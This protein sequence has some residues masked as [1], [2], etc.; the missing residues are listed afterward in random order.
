MASLTDAPTTVTTASPGHPPKEEVL[1]LPSR[2]QPG[3][4]GISSE[5]AVSPG[6]APIR[7]G[8]IACS[9]RL[10]K[11]GKRAL[12][13]QGGTSGV[14]CRSL[15]MFLCIAQGSFCSKFCAAAAGCILAIDTSSF[16]FIQ[17]SISIGTYKIT[18]MPIR[19]FPPSG[20]RAQTRGSEANEV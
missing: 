4:E 17:R 5:T 3:E 14:P 6:C 16:L 11:G 12:D 10:C 19:R 18:N 20:Q 7:S 13:Q 2:A 15:E 1:V 8:L 9:P